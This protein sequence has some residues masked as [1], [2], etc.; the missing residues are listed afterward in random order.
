MIIYLN[1][2][3]SAGKSTLACELQK[4][5]DQPIFYF[6]IDT[7]LYSLP[8]Q[9]I[10]SIEGKQP[11]PAPIN[12]AEIFQG[13]FD[14]IAALHKSGNTVIADCP[15]YSESIFSF[16]QKALQHIDGKFIFG[17]ICPLETL[18]QREVDRK[19]RAIGLAEKQ[20]EGIHKYLTYD[21]AMDSS[22]HDISA[23]AEELMKVLNQKL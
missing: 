18:K 21:L 11:H 15:V 3:S 23:M 16:Y 9:I 7:L 1:G 10:K 4:K 12:W 13:Y 22:Q 6:S 19:D 14:C 8:P 5:L 17:V 20:F 2:T